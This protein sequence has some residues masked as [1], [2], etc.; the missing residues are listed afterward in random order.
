MTAT[1]RK[2]F[3][4]IFL[5]FASALVLRSLAAGLTYYPVLDDSIQ[6]INFQRSTDFWK[7]I[8]TEGLFASR[9]LAILVDLFFVGPMKSHLIVPV[10]IIA[11]LHGLAGA[12]FLRLFERYFGSGMI[13][14]VIY[15]LIPLNCEGVHWLSASTRIVLGLLFTAIA[16]NIFESFLA[17]GKWWRIPLFALSV[18]ASYGLYEQILALSFTL[19]VLQALRYRKDRRALAVLAAPAMVAVYFVFTSM[20]A[21]DGS[22]GARMQIVLPTSWWYFDSF[23]PDL[24]KQIGAAFIKGGALTL[25]RGF[26]RGIE[27]SPW[28]IVY[29]L[30][31]VGAGVAVYF[32]S[33]RTVNEKHQKPELSVIIWGVLLFLAPISPYFVI[34]NPNFALRAATPTLVGAGLVIDALLR[35]LLRREWVYAATTGV[36]TA[37]F[38]VAGASEVRDYYA[39]GKYDDTLARVILSYEDEFEGRVGILGLEAT[40]PYEQNYFYNG[41]IAS[42]AASDWSLYGKLA[43]VSEHVPEFSPVPL[44]CEDFSF[45]RNWN[46]DT[47]R[48]GGFDQIWLWNGTDMTLTLLTVTPNGGEHDFLFYLHD[49]TYVGRVWEEDGIGYVEMV[50]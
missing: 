50:K 11:A 8:K 22:I 17:Y 10:M 32:A 33:R 7:L 1:A 19:T 25:F 49:G 13:F 30:L 38:L 16:A 36:L 37:T 34:G 35:T 9:P 4:I 12:L 15:A 18:L 26:V 29:I 41:H 48:I 44:S 14:A 21:S 42:C 46:R 20:N 27:I 24:I 31:S 39:V 5:I 2:R 6:Y 3:L 28:G 47:K 40:A 45:Y 43:S 23:L